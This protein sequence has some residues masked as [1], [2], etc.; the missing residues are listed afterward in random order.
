MGLWSVPEGWTLVS[1][2][3]QVER[4]RVRGNGEG[5]RADGK[6]ELS[7]TRPRMFGDKDCGILVSSA[8]TQVDLVPGISIAAVLAAP[9][10]EPERAGR[11]TSVS[12]AGTIPG[13]LLWKCITILAA[14]LHYVFPPTD[15]AWL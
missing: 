13:V 7:F 2:G 8:S 10:G 14:I 5:G 12:E 1:G 4:E 11:P 6:E 15:T 9:V 3:R